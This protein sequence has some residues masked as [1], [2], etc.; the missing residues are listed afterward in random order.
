MRVAQLSHAEPAI[1]YASCSL[2]ALH[3]MQAIIQQKDSSN[4]SAAVGFRQYSLDQYNRAISHTQTLIESSASGNYEA[5]TK[6]LV[7]CVL[8]V[9]YENLVGNYKT[10]MMHL[11]NGLKMVEKVRHESQSL[12][13]SGKNGF[14]LDIARIL[15]RLDFQAMAFSEASALYPFNEVCQKIEITQIPD[16]ITSFAEATAIIVDIFRWLIT[17]ASQTEPTPLQIQDIKPGVLALSAW[18]A[19]FVQFVARYPAIAQKHKDQIIILRMYYLML[20]ILFSTRVFGNEML[21]DKRVKDYEM[22][23]ALADEYIKLR[24]LSIEDLNN[25]FFSYEFG[26][27]FPLFYTATKCRDPVIRRRAIAQMYS[28]KY[29]EGSLD[30]CGAAKVAECVM[31]IEEEDFPIVTEAA[32][33]ALHRRVYMTYNSVNVMTRSIKCTCIQAPEGLLSTLKLTEREFTF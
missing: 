22:I 11:Q 21:N 7:A 20:A 33:V 2:S 18:Q 29:Q 19:D 16:P 4:K 27:L 6:A 8:F 12:K 10:A 1:R 28:C 26:I 3:R 31:Q 13:R 15:W 24:E 14:P 30:G 32:D 9:C 5:T 17:L 23:V 25:R